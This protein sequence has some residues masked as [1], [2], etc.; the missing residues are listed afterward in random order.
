RLFDYAVSLPDRLDDQSC[1]LAAQDDSFFASYFA[2]PR[3]AARYGEKFGFAQVPWGMAVNR[4]GSERL[5]RALDLM[6]EIFHRD[7]VF[8]ASARAHRIGTAFL[9][10][11]AAIW[12]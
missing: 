5:G 10:Q 2:D 3:F 1:T 12:A 4:N 8:L 7:G 6:S 11:Q 9:E